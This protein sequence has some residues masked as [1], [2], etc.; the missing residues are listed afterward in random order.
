MRMF[1]L[2]LFLS[3]VAPAGPVKKA[4]LQPNIEEPMVPGTRVP[5]E[6]MNTA[7]TEPK[8]SPEDKEFRGTLETRKQKQEQLLVNPKPLEG[9]SSP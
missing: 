4:D 9:R 3:A 7:P 2:L 1:F 6:R 8:I 5:I